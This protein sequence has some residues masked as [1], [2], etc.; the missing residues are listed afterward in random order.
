MFL[1]NLLTA[2][3]S[4]VP[5]IGEIANI[6]VRY[7]WI[8]NIIAAIIG[9]AK[10]VGLGIILFTVILK[11][12][13]LAPDVW[14]RVSMKKNALKME[15]M[16]EDLEK[17]QKQYAKNKDLYQQ[18]MM[19]LY[20]K[21]GYSAFSA[22][23]PTIITLVF[24]FIVI[25]AFNSYSQV[26]ERDIFDGMRVAY[27][28]SIEDLS[29]EK[30]SSVKKVETTDENGNVHVAYYLDY[31]N[32]FAKKG[33]S[34]C[35]V[36]VGDDFTADRTKAAQLIAV[37][38]ED[39]EKIIRADGTFNPDYFEFKKI[40]DNE[41]QSGLIKRAEA[42]G[43][44][45]ALITAGAID[46]PKKDG[47]YYIMDETL[48]WATCPDLADKYRVLNDKE[49]TD[50]AA[51]IENA[52]FATEKASFEAKAEAKLTDELFKVIESKEVEEVRVGARKAAAEWYEGDGNKARS[53]IFPWVKNIWASDCSWT[54]ALPANTEALNQKIKVGMSEV[55]YEELTHDL[56]RYKEKGFKNGNGWFILVALSILAMAG[57]TII[58]NKTQKTQMQLS[59]VDGDNSTAASTQKMM[60]WMM[61]IMFGI[62]SFIYSAAFSIYMVTNS[63]LSTG[64]T[65]LI[66]LIVEKSFKKKIAKDEQEKLENHKYGKMR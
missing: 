54:T 31:S 4:I 64:S 21:N 11:L 17:L 14:S 25:G 30:N 41:V 47:V 55:D 24:F 10:D 57:S 23:L 1:T 63:L 28:Q 26:S 39:I 8:C 48:F 5:S 60:T 66:N 15:A 58:M 6:S 45:D 36:V 22:C 32:I 49:E 9:F 16:K 37:Y 43:L 29:S 50:Y 34:G 65:L 20:K 53:V 18:K 59:S 2:V 40:I 44:K 51:I 61:P 38:G 7:E 52:D 19:A 56:G 3:T 33:V 12:I 35:F 62:F 42:A 46:S 27:N 13:T